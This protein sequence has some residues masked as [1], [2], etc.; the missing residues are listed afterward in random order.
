MDL[1]VK[2]TIILTR[3]GCRERS[4]FSW[5]LRSDPRY[6]SGSPPDAIYQVTGVSLDSDHVITGIDTNR[7]K[8]KKILTILRILYLH[9]CLELDNVLGL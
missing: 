1:N 3:S 4:V 6:S 9:F 7:T 5:G 2:F 8:K